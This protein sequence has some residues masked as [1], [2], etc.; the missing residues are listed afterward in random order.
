MGSVRFAFIIGF[1]FVY[2]VVVFV[3]PKMCKMPLCHF[4]IYSSQIA[5][6]VAGIR[7]RQSEC[8]GFE[9][10]ISFHVAI[11]VQIKF[12]DNSGSEFACGRVCCEAVRLADEA[13]KPL[14]DFFD[15]KFNHAAIQDMHYTLR[16]AHR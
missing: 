3:S 7:C 1:L 4:H 9:H 11:I 6:D 2:F 14:E 5:C 12:C 16:N 8:L 10:Q 13:I 15:V